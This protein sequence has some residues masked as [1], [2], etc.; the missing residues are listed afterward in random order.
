MGHYYSEMRGLE[1]HEKIE[2]FLSEQKKGATFTLTAES[3][4]EITLTRLDI[5]QLLRERSAARQELAKVRS[6]F[7]KLSRL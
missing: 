6:M 1:P 5:R 3:G 7:R 2:D 4:E